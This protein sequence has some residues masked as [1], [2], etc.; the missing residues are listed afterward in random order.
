MPFSARAEV[1]HTGSQHIPV[2]QRRAWPF[3]VQ[4]EPGLRLARLWEGLPHGRISLLLSSLPD[5]P[6][7]KFCAHML[8]HD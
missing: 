8:D 2:S 1:R 6:A 4:T 5:V 3:V 7:R